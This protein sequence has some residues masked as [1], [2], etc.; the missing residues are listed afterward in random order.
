MPVS[1]ISQKEEAHIN[2]IATLWQ[3]DKLYLEWIGTD[4]FDSVVRKK[5]SIAQNEYRKALQRYE[6]LFGRRWNE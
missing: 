1:L 5:L 4:Y 6:N 3:Y 2:V